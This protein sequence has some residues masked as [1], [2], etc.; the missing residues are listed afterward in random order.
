[1]TVADRVKVWRSRIKYAEVKRKSFYEGRG[2]ADDGLRIGAPG[3]NFA[4][5]VYR[6]NARPTWWPVEDHFIHVGK[7]KAAV[8]AAVPSLLYKDPDYQVL[9]KS[10]DRDEMGQDISLERARSKRLWVNHWWR[11]SHGLQHARIGIQ[12]AFFDIGVLCGGYRCDFADD[13]KRGVFAKTEDGLYILDEAGDPTL[14]RGEFLYDEDGEVQRDQ[15]GLPVLHQGTVQ[16]EQFFVETAD[17]HDFLFDTDSGADFF[18]HRWLI[19]ERLLPL[20]DVKRDPRYPAG[21]RK[22]LKGTETLTGVPTHRK[23]E[24]SEMAYE[25]GSTVEAVQR[26]QEMIRFYDIYDFEN[27]EFMVLPKEGLEGQNEEFMLDGPMPDGMEH[28]PYRFLK[29]TEDIGDEWYPIPDA[30]DMALLNQEYDLTRSQEF[31]H[32]DHTK[33]RYEVK[34][35]TFTGE[36]IDSDV[37]MEKLLRGPDGG[38]VMVSSLG[39]I[40]PIEKAQLDGSYMRATPQIAMDFNEV[41]GM[42]GEMRGVSDADTATQASILA[43]GA[44]LRNND[45]RDN[46]VQTWLQEIGRVLLMSGQANSELDTLVIE[47]CVEATGVAPF[48]IHKLSREELLGE[49]AVEVSIDSTKPKNDPRVLQQIAAFQANL[50]QNPLLGMNKGLNRRLLDGMGLDPVLAD[51]LY[52]FAMQHAQMNAKTPQQGAPG[53]Q[54]QVLPQDLMGMASAQGGVPTGAPAN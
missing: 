22:R 18:K 31:I 3:A 10:V 5:E 13:N 39:G 28:G 48:T 11:E 15:D 21:V 41:G 7:L 33:S 2:V 47:K 20:E 25:A 30:T 26:D 36:G 1:M 32:R 35:G 49:F 29:Y 23:S 51:E 54:G 52:D 4:I 17:C 8:R 50:A 44:E 43:T 9:P 37:E 34:V 27:D 12:N 45:R 19:R 53:A 6:G 24:N 42:P 46:Q 16:K 38:H 14:E 40:K